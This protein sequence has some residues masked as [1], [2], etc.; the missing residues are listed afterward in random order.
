[1]PSIQPQPHDIP[2]DFVV[3]ENGVHVAG[4]A[5]LE[6]ITDRTRVAALVDTIAAERHWRLARARGQT[7]QQAA[8]DVRFAGQGSFSRCY[9]R[10]VEPGDGDG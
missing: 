6:L 9:A 2:M 10:A 5:G 1:M 4:R 8:G 7:P 3:T